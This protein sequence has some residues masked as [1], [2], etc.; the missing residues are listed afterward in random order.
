MGGV[1]RVEEDLISILPNSLFLSF[2]SKFLRINVGTFIV[3]TL[4]GICTES[5]RPPCFL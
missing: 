5:V 1:R 3:V 2:D 4:G